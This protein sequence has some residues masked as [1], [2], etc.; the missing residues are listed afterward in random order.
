MIGTRRGKGHHVK[1]KAAT[2][3]LGAVAYGASARGASASGSEALGAAAFGAVA[4]GALAIR[5]LAIG[6]GKIGHLSIGDLE[7]G[8]LRVGELVVESRRDLH[9]FDALEKHRFVRLTTFRKSDETVA[10][11]VWFALH[12]G[13]LYVT[14][15]PGSGKM[16]R[17]RNNPGVTLTPC[18]ARGRAR[19]ESIE[20]VG[21]LLANGEA[22]EGAARAFEDK[23]RLG[24]GLLR[25]FRSREIGKLTLEIRPED[26]RGGE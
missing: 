9:P 6:R 10:T 12:E 11:P 3:A 19:G 22:P 15:D 17:I 21:R 7:V 13:R 16:K 20:A 18:D 23:Y 24:L 14:T 26:R 2:R 5:R 25:F 8:R 1:K 4:V